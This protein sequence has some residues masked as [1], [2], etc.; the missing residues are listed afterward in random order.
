MENEVNT[1]TNTQDETTVVETVAPS[2]DQGKSRRNSSG[3]SQGGRPDRRP[4]KEAKVK[5]EY[6]QR[7][8]DIRRVTRV[9]AGG[10]RFSF[11]VALVVGNKKGSVGVATGKAGDTALAIE[12]AYK[13]AKK[14]A[15]LVNLTKHAS[16]PHEVDAKFKSARVEI[17]PAKGRGVVSGS[18]V[19][20]VIELAGIRDVNS[21]LRSPTKNKLNIAR[22]TIKALATLRKVK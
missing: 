7:I 11:S 16:I 1:Q 15:M 14:K 13:A 21:K 20:D 4:R 12:K 19:R 2:T 3:A 18:A 5:P 9:A 8:L 22:A 10:R 17:M 6:D